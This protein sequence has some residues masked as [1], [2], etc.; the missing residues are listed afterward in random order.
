MTL[1]L[2]SALLIGLSAFTLAACGDFKQSTA[3]ASMFYRDY[4]GPAAAAGVARVRLSAEGVVRIT[5]GSDCAD[6]TRPE[7]GVALYSAFSLK[8]YSY[9]HDRKLGMSGEPPAGLVS[10]EVTLKANEPAVITYSNSW[11]LRGTNYTCHVH[12]RVLPA[13]DAQYQLVARADQDA[14][15]CVVEL[16]DLAEPGREVPVAPAQRCPG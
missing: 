9:L 4:A 5:P 13:A 1:R 15:D 10:T 11:T 12:R 2:P 6:F 16:T 3:E 8:D 14:G 7:T